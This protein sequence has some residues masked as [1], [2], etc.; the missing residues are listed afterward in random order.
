MAIICADNEIKICRLFMR[1]NKTPSMV[2]LLFARDNCNDESIYFK[3]FS[4]NSQLKSFHYHIQILY[5]K[6]I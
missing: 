2:N 4:K 3:L 6:Y 5:E 1:H